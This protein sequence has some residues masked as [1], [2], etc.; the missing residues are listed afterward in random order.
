MTTGVLLVINLA[1]FTMLAIAAVTIARTRHLFTAAM[2]SG[3]FSLVSA[4][5]FVLQDAV[6]VA[7]TEAAVGA[8][9]TTVLFLVTL[10]VSG[11]REQR[12]TRRRGLPAA[13]SA[14]VTG[15]ALLYASLDLPQ[16]GAADTPV[17][18]H[19]L[20][21]R[22][23]E[24]SAREI[25]IPNVVTSVLASYRGYDTMGET[26]VIFAAA[27][28]VLM[29]LGRAPRTPITQPP[30]PALQE[31]HSVLRIITKLLVP[32][33]LLFAFYVQFHGDYGPGGGFQAGVIFATGLILYALVF[34]LDAARRVVPVAAL[35]V[36]VA[37]GLLLYA[38]TGCV[39]LLLG[40]AF[41]DYD[42]LVPDDPVSGQHVGIL[43]VELGVGITVASAMTLLYFAFA[44]RERTR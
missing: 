36:L 30:R 26:A 29:L 3:L 6:D 43:I 9:M 17:Q 40:G 39:T 12:Y 20:T 22:Y 19:P 10:A 38:G 35:R 31:Q 34:G 41:L 32:A 1:L 18:Q 15:A 28:G 42:V 24:D 37:L 25:G 8:G 16:Y 27:I 2:L 11:A 4:C 44:G 7:F 23:L 13:L 33:I 21:A 14:I 5:I